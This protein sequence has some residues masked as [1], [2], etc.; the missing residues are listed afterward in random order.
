MNDLINEIK[1][2]RNDILSVDKLEKILESYLKKYPFYPSKS[3]VEDLLDNRKVE[4]GLDDYVKKINKRYEKFKKFIDEYS[5]AKQCRIEEVDTLLN[6]N[7]IPKEKINKAKEYIESGK[8]FAIDE[9][10]N[11]LSDL[12]ASLYNPVFH[13]YNYY[14]IRNYQ[15]QWFIQK[16]NLE[17][18]C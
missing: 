3:A 16:I 5:K 13:N 17:T 8:C 10:N 14:F 15:Q 1:K 12:K 11:F 7:K 2:R 6:S 4:C 9:Y 18:S